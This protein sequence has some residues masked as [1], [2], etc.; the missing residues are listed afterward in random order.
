M[1]VRSGANWS[2]Q[3]TLFGTGLT[4]DLGFQGASVAL[5]ADGNTALVGGVMD[6]D[7]SQTTFG[8]GAAWVFTRS[9]GVWTQQG[10]K[11][12]G[13]GAV[14]ASDQGL[15]VALSADGNTALVGGDLDNG[16]VG[17][18]WV[19]TR[20]GGVWTQ[21]GPKLTGTPVFGTG[22]FGSSVAV[23]SDGNTAVVGAHDSSG[24]IGALYPFTRSGGV[25][26]Q[27]SFPLF[28][29]GFT[30]MLAPQMGISIALSGDGN[31]AILGGYDDGDEAGA[32][33]SFTR[34]GSAWTQ[35]GTKMVGSGALGKANQGWRVAISTDGLT[36]LVG[37]PLDNSNAGAAWI[38]VA[39]VPAVTQQPVSLGACSGAP[40]T[41]SAVGA[42]W[43]AATVIWQV[44]TDGGATFNDILGAIS[45]N[46]TF[47]A[48]NAL[49]GNQYRAVFTN[50][51]GTTT[52][53]AATLSVGTVPV[54][55]TNPVTQTVSA[56]SPVTFTAAATG[57][58]AP[59]VQWFV[60]HD[61][62]ITFAAI[63]GR[64]RPR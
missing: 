38:F 12:V 31:T 28:G 40:V 26:T 29:G 23:S 10:S 46:L 14:G 34:S 58:P 18:V 17:A 61:G 57:T 59:T 54:V 43:P 64:P 13:S 5:S 56:G 9:G 7:G 55:T 53:G 1:W 25:W 2:K 6:G 20:S 44:S 60:S 52:S 16:F 63:P 27:Q 35:Q 33:W 24:A 42:S 19:W 37:G 62:G 39:T 21:Q 49:S 50:S 36:A 4:G 11:L 15:S 51:L 30:G 32:T 47:T 45:T 3:A 8:V 22:G 41:F 48:T